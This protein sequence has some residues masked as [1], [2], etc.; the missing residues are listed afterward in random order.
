MKVRYSSM[1]LLYY[2]DWNCFIYFV[3]ITVDGKKVT[4]HYLIVG[5]LPFFEDTLSERFRQATKAT[6]INTERIHRANFII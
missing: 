4:G 3:P 2:N 1:T 5:L 6:I